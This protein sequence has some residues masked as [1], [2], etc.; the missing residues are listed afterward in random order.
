MSG[1]KRVMLAFTALRKAGKTAVLP[2][3]RELLSAS[4]DNLMNICLMA[5]VKNQLILRRIEHLMQS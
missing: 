5:N 1:A 4:G 2:E 3:R